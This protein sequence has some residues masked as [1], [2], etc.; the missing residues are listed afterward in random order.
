[1]RNTKRIDIFCD[2]LKK[3]WHCVP[4]WRFGQLMSNMLG[5]FVAETGQDIFFPEDDEMM[6]FFM[7]FAETYSTY[8][9]KPR[10]EVR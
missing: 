5:D 7:K 8:G 10:Y 6:N 1:M 2:Q 3:V 9:K 4:D